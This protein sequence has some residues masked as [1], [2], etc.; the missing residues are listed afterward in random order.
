[1]ILWSTIKTIYNGLKKIP[2]IADTLQNMTVLSDLLEEN[3]RLKERIGS[4]ESTN[5]FTMKFEE[6]A[7]YK[8]N[9]KNHEKEGPF[10]SVC[11]DKDKKTCRLHKES[12]SWRCKVCRNLFSNHSEPQEN[13][14]LGYLPDNWAGPPP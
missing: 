13:D 11:W 4:L 9:S 12:K 8:I 6:F 2:D 3:K 7:Y 14:P 5:M 10:C 1:V